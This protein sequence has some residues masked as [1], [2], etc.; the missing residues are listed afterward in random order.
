MA[1]ESGVSVITVQHAY[2]ILCDEGYIEAK[3]RSGY[4]V[5]YRKDEFLPTA[6][7]AVDLTV[8]PQVHSDEEFPLS[9]FARTMR[10]AI[11]KYGEKL[12]IKAPNFGIWELRHAIS[13]YLAR[14][15]GWS[16]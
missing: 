13:A 12:L 7:S 4:F 8:L 14:V 5:A 9:V 3:E 2:E 16:Y 10:N 1:D 15:W 6:E 11:S